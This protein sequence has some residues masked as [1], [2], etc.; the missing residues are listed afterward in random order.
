MIIFYMP[1]YAC[2]VVAIAPVTRSAN[3]LTT[4]IERN[5]SKDF[6]WLG[7]WVMVLT[8]FPCLGKWV[9]VSTDFPWLGKWVVASTD[10]SWLGKQVMVIKSMMD[11][12]LTIIHR[13][14]D[15]ETSTA[16][17]E[18]YGKATPLDVML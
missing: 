17:C 11:R 2:V 7:K 16:L 5:R 14:E 13:A 3:A 6:P 10:F 12:L 15:T 9:S 8:D 1:L 18:S 4:L